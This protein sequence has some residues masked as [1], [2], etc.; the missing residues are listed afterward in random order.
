MARVRI[1]AIL[2]TRLKSVFCRK[3]AIDSYV[4]HSPTNCTQEEKMAKINQ[5][6][7]R[8]SRCN[9][10]RD[11]SSSTTCQIGDWKAQ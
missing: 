1:R 5:K 8:K 10:P 3:N 9:P 7:T 4:D 11:N 2:Y 6:W